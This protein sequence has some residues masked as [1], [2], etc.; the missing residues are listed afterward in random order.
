MESIEYFNNLNINKENDFEQ[1]MRYLN[2]KI[3]KL[4]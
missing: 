1:H 4:Q 2:E 3:V